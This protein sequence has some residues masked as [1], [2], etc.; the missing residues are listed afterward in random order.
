M[1]QILQNLKSGELMLEDVPVPQVRS[2]HLLIETRCSLISAGT[3]RM[4]V[5]FGRAGLIEKALQKPDKVRQVID[6]VKT[7]G[8]AATLDAVNARLDQPIALGY[9][10]VGRVVAVGEGVSG[11]SVGDRVVSNGKHAEAVLSPVHL[12]AKIPD[13]VRDEDAAFTVLSSIAL[14]GVR[15]VNPTLG[16]YVCVMGLGLIGLI[17][18]QILRASGARVIGFDFDAD[19]VA[20]AKEY[21]ADAYDLST[22]I[23]PVRQAMEFSQGQG[24]DG[25]LITAATKSNDVVKHSAQMSRQRGRVVLTGVVGLDLD[26]AD[27]YE[28]E[29]TFQVS[30]SYGPGRYDPL[31]EEAGQDYPVGF[32]RW[33]EQRNF[34]AVLHLMAEGKINTTKLLTKRVPLLSA[35]DAY[36]LLSD[37]RHIGMLIEYPAIEKDKGAALVTETVVRTIQPPVKAEGRAV[38]GIIGAGGFTAGQVL[39]ALARTPARL[40]WI[41]SAGGVSGA[42]AAR[43]FSIENN[44]TD[45][46]AILQDPEVNAVIITT[47]HGSHAK[48]VL[49]SLAAGKHV[50]VEKPLCLTEEELAAIVREQA[51]QSTRYTRALI[52]MVGFNRRFSPLTDI[53]QQHLRHRQQPLTAVY[54]VNAGYIPPDHWVHDA[55]E[56]GGRILGEACHFIDYLLYLTGAEIV[57]VD[58]HA[59]GDSACT[60]KDTASIT[61]TFSDGSLG[62][63]NYIATG[64]KSYPKEQCQIFVDGKVFDLDNFRALRAHGTRGF[65]GKKLWRQDKGHAAGFAAFVSAVEQGASQPIPL[66]EVYAVT[67]ATLAADAMIVGKLVAVD[68]AACDEKLP[69]VLL[70]SA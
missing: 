29:I 14:Q 27:F 46:T 66:A 58:A 67:S 69:T 4:I 15:L 26:R 48:F 18:V 62:V 32:V 68:L 7:D 35:K 54:T 22:G 23:D 63:V 49:E 19:R 51:E 59:L 5:D 12:C 1:K 64:H 60:T 10:N 42:N 61:L 34:E 53:L 24:I 11:Y 44:T 39:P 36:D 28:K 70:R 33:T 43:K 56:G 57:R 41:S 9:S 3:E 47:R 31:Y 38:I 40:K 52:V 20:L 37:K 8:F 16:E 45:Y 21:G 65:S 30:C 13:S 6:K 50:F 2:G 17:A 25:V 55:H